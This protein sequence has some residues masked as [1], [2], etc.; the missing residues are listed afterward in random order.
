MPAPYPPHPVH[1]ILLIEDTEAV[2]HVVERQLVTLGCEVVAVE[3]G[4][5]ALE[6]LSHQKFSFIFT[7]FHLPDKDGLDL[8]VDIRKL[9]NGRDVPITLITA[10]PMDMTA[11]S[12]RLIGYLQK[13]ISRADL[14]SVLGIKFDHEIC[15]LRPAGRAVDLEALRDQMGELDDG[16]IEM[17][18]MFSG[19]M[20]PLLNQLI[21]AVEDDDKASIKEFAHS[22]KG[23]ARSVG[24]LQMG[25]I[26]GLLQQAGEEKIKMDLIELVCKLKTEFQRVED[27]LNRLC[28]A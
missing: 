26:C 13:P 17:I 4:S 8:I 28:A 7:D 19:M 20:R 23:A 18:G 5:A 25:D 12:D 24:A 21:A 15:G 6:V 3:N 27:D 11:Q 16:A 10:D 14:Q 2:R 22:L 9:Q 1:R